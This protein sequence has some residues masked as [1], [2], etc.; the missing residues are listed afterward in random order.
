MS[1]EEKW[2]QLV[3]EKR[4]RR[5]DA[6]PKAWILPNHPPDL[7][8][9]THIP[10]Q[11]GLLSTL[12][13][14]ITNSPVEVLLA[15]LANATW[16]AVAVTTAFAKRAVIAHQLTN[17]LTE[18]FIDRALERAAWL[19]EQLKSTGRVVGPLHGL[20]IS[21]KDQVSVKGIESTMG[22][23]SWIGQYAERNSVLADI[24]EEQGA[25]LYVKTNI[26]QTL[27]WAETFNHVFGRTS[28]PYNRSLTS[29][30]SSGGEGALVA[31]KGSPIGVG[32]DIGGSIRIPSAFNGLY[33][34]RP[35]FNR[36]PY[37]GSVNSMEG[38]DAIPSVLGPMTTSIEGVKKFM[39]SVLA[40]KPWNRDP[41]AL[42][43][44]W[45][46]DAYN[47]IEHGKCEEPLCFGILWNDGMVHPHPPI[48]RA[49][50]MVKNALLAKGHRVID[51]E[52]FKHMEIYENSRRIYG[53]VGRED[54]QAATA[55]TGE[56]I[57]SSMTTEYD[58]YAVSGIV[59]PEVDSGVEVPEMRPFAGQPPLSAFE[60]WG[61]HK[62]R[63]DLRREYLEHWQ[64]TASRTGTGRPVDAIISP[65][66]SSAAPPHGMNRL[67]VYTWIWNNL[68]YPAVVIPVTRVDQ[69][70]DVP[71][72]EPEFFGD[73]DRTVH[74]FYTPER[75]GNAPVSVQIVGRTQEDEAVIRM[76]D[77]IDKAMKLVVL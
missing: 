10:E 58:D 51:W 2:R 68:D 54:F 66:A 70:L 73:L 6:I 9:V 59:R 21:L 65:V 48:I 12:E 75:F 1:T 14:Q 74:K 22:Y 40:A 69:E 8:D 24:L 42:R 57:I 41:I 31:L 35:S 25:V 49:L 52:P 55:S 46:E 5:D 16:S 4:K 17:C 26:P 44:Q 61:V 71:G 32:S 64:G 18:I 29:G 43:K 30:G 77:I 45:D 11:C 37:A 63:Q 50:E 56:P 47:L 15:N 3:I 13:I 62:K 53:A 33:G 36:I 7:L 20:P 38:Q 72:P 27:M 39:T 28:N 67:A 76:G 23:V 60:L 34:F 19:D